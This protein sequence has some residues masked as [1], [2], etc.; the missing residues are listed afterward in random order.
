LPSWKLGWRRANGWRFADI[1]HVATALQLGAETFLTFDDN[2]C[3]LAETE[4]L[5]VP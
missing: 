3:A 1:L 2:Q 4:G 5:V